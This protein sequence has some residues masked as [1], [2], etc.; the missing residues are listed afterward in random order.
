MLAV[1]SHFVQ[2]QHIISNMK[3][4]LKKTIPI[5]IGK[6]LEFVS[7]FSPKKAHNMA[8]RLFCKPLKGKASPEQQEFLGDAK[9]LIVH[10]EN[11]EIQT[12]RWEGNPNKETIILVHGWESNSHRW[13]T[14]IPTFLNKGYN[15]VALD[16]PAQ[17]NS[18]GTILNVPLYTECLEAVIKVHQPDIVI[19]HSVGGM[20][21]IFHQYKYPNPS[22]KKLAVL[23]PPSELSLIMKGFQSTLKLSDRFMHSLNQFFK[24]R[25]GFFYH[26]FSIAA[27][28]ADIQQDGLIIHDRLDRI[29]PFAA[30][31]AIH[32]NW[33]NSKLI[34]TKGF[35]HSLYHPDVNATLLEFIETP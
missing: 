13:K 9:D 19:G 25:F 32:K 2:M 27:F 18:S 35:G 17:G 3:K 29:A 10:V 28:A 21:T 22:I 16:A 23:G 1:Y 5:L 15:I 26:E 11:I 24:D 6:Q 14:I 4:L 30:S 7:F 33:K 12:Y 20:T 31:K 8:F 34:A